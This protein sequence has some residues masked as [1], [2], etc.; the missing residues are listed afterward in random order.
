MPLSLTP[1]RERNYW[2]HAI[3]TEGRVGSIHVVKDEMGEFLVYRGAGRARQ[4]GIDCTSEIYTRYVAPG[5]RGSGLSLGLLRAMFGRLW[6]EGG[7]FA[8][9]WVLAATPEQF[10]YHEMDGVLAA[11]SLYVTRNV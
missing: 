1:E 11:D 7:N 3:V 6:R 2:N 8:V 10:F 4:C 9:I 5:H